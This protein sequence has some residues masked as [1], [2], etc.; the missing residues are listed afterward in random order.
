MSNLPLR[1]VLP[2]LPFV[3]VAAAC[4]NGSTVGAGGAGSSTGAA[5]GA[6]STASSGATTASGTGGAS[7]STSTTSGTSSASGSGGG[8]SACTPGSTKA[9]YSGP[10]TTLD[11]GAC[12]AGTATCAADG[13]FGP[14][15][16]EVLPVP[17]S[18][19]TLVD[20][21]CNGAT[22]EGCVCTPNATMSCYGGPPGTE[23]VGICK[24]GTQ[25]CAADGL[26]F[27]PCMGQVTPKTE[28]CLSPA[29][30]DCSGTAAACTGNGAWAK[31]FGDAGVQSGAAVAAHV[32]GAVIT[33]SFAGTTDFGGGV[34]TSAG[35]TDVFLASY[36]YLG[37]FLWAKR[38]GDAGAQAG[39][40][41]AVDKLGNLVVIGDFAGTIDLGGGA[42]TSAGNTDVFVA[43][44]DSGGGF[45]WAK[46]FGDAVAQ[47]GK[48]IAV[49]D[50]GDVIITGSFAGKIDLGGGSLTSAG[51]TDV[52]LAKLD[53]A[54]NHLWSKRFGDASA[55][56]GKSVGVDAAGNVVLTGDVAGG[57]DFGG[58][59]LTSAGGT[60][61]FLAS[62]GADGSYFWAKLFGDAG[63]QTSGA[64]AVDA[65][66]NVVITGNAAGKTNFGGGLLT[67]AGASDVY[68]ARF[69]SAGMHLWSK[70]FGGTGAENGRDV[71]VD[72]FGGIVITG[73]FPT[74]INFGGGAL[75]SA[76]GTDVFAVKLDPQAGAH[77]WSRRFGD[78]G[79]QTAAGVAADDTG[80][81]LVGTFAG[82]IDFGTGALTSAGMTDVYL[83]K[84]LP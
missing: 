70:L 30:E 61:V 9:C 51:A 57:A 69:T 12:K 43:K 74:T 10:S 82:S 34:L 28:D 32:G 76:G 20:D 75:T 81:L 13:T 73:D 29:D 84:L 6:S 50:A 60:D 21:N 62:F 44:F 72:S 38:F 16:G 65:V 58:G 55:Q 23:N 8:P 71:A 49:D 17:E 40:D 77:V 22:N 59:V 5:G 15:V 68:A 80:A 83:A 11:I 47:N 25:T 56:S 14:C 2:A 33:G 24:A 42:L 41:I 66:G 54:G 35:A 67:S 52:F 53:P 45:V 4:G 39:V 31:R 37:A 27:S 64:V 48:G 7:T 18:C 79:A 19:T 26:S 46:R 63:A 3:L 36:D 1:R 78:A